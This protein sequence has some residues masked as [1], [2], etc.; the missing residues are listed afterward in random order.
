MSVNFFG[1]QFDL[2]YAD[3]IYEN[4]DLNWIDGFWAFLKNNGVFIVQTDWH[5]NY[6]VRKRFESIKIGLPE[7][8]V[9]I[10]HLVWKNEWGQ[11]PSRKCI[12]VMMTLLFMQKEI[13]ISFIQIKFR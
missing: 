1:Q 4:E 8:P 5:T 6:L 12:S 3:M 7:D 11:H 2:I 13:I 9:F 10:N